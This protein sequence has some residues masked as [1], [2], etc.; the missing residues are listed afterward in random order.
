VVQIVNTSI[1]PRL[2]ELE[3]AKDYNSERAA[4]TLP[5]RHGGAVHLSS[6][7][8]TSKPSRN[9]PSTMSDCPASDSKIRPVRE[10]RFKALAAHLLGYVGAP[11]D[12]DKLPDVNN[13]TFYQP[14]WKGSRRSN[15]C[16]TNGFAGRPACASS[17]A[18]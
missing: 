10:Y 15:S 8:S 7:N 6:R 12:I 9:S 13:Y 2:E 5:Q 17:S 14:T 16:M 3:L 1:I 4:K 18:A 11:N